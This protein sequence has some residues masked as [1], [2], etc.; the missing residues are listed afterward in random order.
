MKIETKD[1]EPPGASRMCI[2]D[3]GSLVFPEISPKLTWARVSATARL[4]ESGVT[5]SYYSTSLSWTNSYLQMPNNLIHQC[6]FLILQLQAENN[7]LVTW[8]RK[9]WFPD[10]M[11]CVPPVTTTLTWVI[12]IILF[13]FVVRSFFPQPGLSSRSLVLRYAFLSPKVYY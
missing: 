10:P 8:P 11:V 5:E 12:F 13:H 2:V 1:E 9:R 3:R 6:P 7:G 4:H